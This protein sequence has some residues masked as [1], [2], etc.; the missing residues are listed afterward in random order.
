M[1]LEQG[2][3]T[4]LAEDG[5]FVVEDFMP[6]G[7]DERLRAH[8]EHLFEEEGDAAGADFRQEPGC[9]RLA[10]LMNKGEIFQAVVAEPRL[11]TYI[12]A[13]LGPDFK[14][15]SLN[16]RSTTPRA[17]RRQPLHT[18]M[19]A[20]PDEQGYWVCN[21]VWLL[22]DFTIDNGALRVVPGSHRWGR[23]PE[24]ALEDPLEPHPD[25]VV[26]TAS[27]GSLIVM[28]AHVWHG[29]LENRTEKPRRALH[30]FY[31]RGDKP[32]QQYQKQLLRAAVQARLSPELRRL[33]ALDDPR[34]DAL[35]AAPT[36]RSGFL[37]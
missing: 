15:S 35:S 5:F 12:A 28:N 13:V 3:R 27:A 17:G 36:R 24:A 22:D 34:N 37:K 9:R 6:S 18:D 21:S 16:A 25:E 23:L 2:Q 30:A 8:I 7:L 1:T 29:G 10:N 14:L 20:L 33:L 31:A 11:L 19:G 32:Q 26:V 4:R